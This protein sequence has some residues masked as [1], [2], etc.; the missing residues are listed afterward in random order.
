LKPL[1]LLLSVLLLALYLLFVPSPDKSS[2]PLNVTTEVFVETKH[3]ITT[4]TLTP[5]KPNLLLK[6]SI[7]E[8]VTKEENCSNELNKTQKTWHVKTSIEGYLKRRRIHNA[9]A[10]DIM[11]SD[12]LRDFNV[13]YRTDANETALAMAIIYND[14]NFAHFLIENGADLFAISGS[15][16]HHLHYLALTGNLKLLNTFIDAG[17]PINALSQRGTTA[18]SLAVNRLDYAFSRALL[19]AGA[20]SST[21]ASDGRTAL[22]E[23]MYIGDKEMIK[24]ILENSTGGI[25]I[26]QHTDLLVDAARALTPDVLDL[27]LNQGA[28]IN[29]ISSAG[30]TPLINAIHFSNPEA[31]SFLIEQGADVNLLTQFGKSALT[32]V[33]NNKKSQPELLT[34]LIQNGAE[35]NIQ[36]HLTKQTVLMRAISLNK[37][38]EAQALLEA[39]ADTTLHDKNGL[40]AHDYA[41]KSENQDMITLMQQY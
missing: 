19:E 2:D 39:G 33:I 24:L 8:I 26:H 15:G 32:T 17:I 10:Y 11:K 40:S 29:A 31:F 14:T 41:Q 16:N 25:D 30:E 37:I 35:L 27:L 36:N 23:A 20:N 3:N 34:I 5:T 12:I 22:N 6:N 28:N 9:A 18:L 38:K 1:L 4:P 21:K 7:I 13:N